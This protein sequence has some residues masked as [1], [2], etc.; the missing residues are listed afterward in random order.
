MYGA[1]VDGFPE[2][3]RAYDDLTRCERRIA[4]LLLGEP[5]V[6][7]LKSAANISSE[8]GISQATTVR[9]FQRLGDPGFKAAQTTA[10][11][12]G[13]AVKLPNLLAESPGRKVG[14]VQNPVL[15]SGPNQSL[16][17]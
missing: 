9:F 6:L 13:E 15:R 11:L 4:D 8:V 7:V 12:G 3:S 10:K 17:L 1:R 2:I 14:H 5:D 16:V